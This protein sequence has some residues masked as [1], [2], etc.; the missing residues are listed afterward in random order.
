MTVCMK[1]TILAAA[2]LLLTACV[3]VGQKIEQASLENIKF[4]ET[5]IAQMIDW[6]GL[7][8]GQLFVSEGKLNMVWQYLTAVPFDSDVKQQ[9]LTV[10]FDEEGKVEKYSLLDNITEEVKSV[11]K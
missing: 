5:T 9:N 6:Y 3:T 11:V 1:K 7:P 8:Q 2:F 4:G 10:L